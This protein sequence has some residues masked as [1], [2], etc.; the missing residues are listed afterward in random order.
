MSTA[1]DKSSKASN[2]SIALVSQEGDNFEVCSS[3]VAISEYIMKQVGTQL[4]DGNKDQIE[5]IQL[6]TISSQTLVRIIDFCRHHHLH[7]MNKI[8]KPLRSADLADLVD[9]WYVDFADLEMDQIIQVTLAANFLGIK[10][11]VDLM[12]A[13][14]ALDIQQKPVKEIRQLF[15]IVND[16]TPEEEARLQLENAQVV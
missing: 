5:E 10:P 12:C 9:D 8:K 1:N 15:D 7:L 2:Q 11:L 16:F 4:I 6:P 3:A 13:R 14:V